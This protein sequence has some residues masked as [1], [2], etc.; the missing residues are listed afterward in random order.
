MGKTYNSEERGDGLIRNLFLRKLN[1]GYL[2]NGEGN[3]DNRSW[4]S[5]EDGIKR[6]DQWDVCCCVAKK[7][8]KWFEER[9]EDNV[10]AKAPCDTRFTTVY[11]DLICYRDTVLVS[12]SNLTNDTSSHIVYVETNSVPVPQ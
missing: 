8:K 7:N 9:E 1:D 3:Y 10:R 11:D 12:A 2:S 4:E 5:I 6:K